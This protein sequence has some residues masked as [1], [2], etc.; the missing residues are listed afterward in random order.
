MARAAIVFKGERL[1]NI[2]ACR[3]DIGDALDKVPTFRGHD[4][5]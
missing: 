2:Q 3:L 5:P 4:P 1:Q